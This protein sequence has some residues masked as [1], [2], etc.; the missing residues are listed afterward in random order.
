[1]EK[2]MSLMERIDY[3]RA[4]SVS[5]DDYKKFWGVSIDEHVSEL[6]RHFDECLEQ[7]RP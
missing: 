1:M 7:T 2:K 3:I 6:M 4:N 5:D